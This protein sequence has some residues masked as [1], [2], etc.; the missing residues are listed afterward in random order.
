M[1][2]WDQNWVFCHQSKQHVWHKPKAVYHQKH[3]ILLVKHS[4][5]S[6]RFLCS[7]PGRFLRA[8]GKINSTKSWWK[9]WWNLQDASY[10]EDLFSSM[11]MTPNKSWRNHKNKKE[12]SRK[13]SR[14]QPIENEL[15][16]LKSLLTICGGGEYFNTIDTSLCLSYL[17]HFRDKWC[18]IS[19]KTLPHNQC[20]SP[21]IMAFSMSY[22]E[23]IYHAS[24]CFEIIFETVII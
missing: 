11:T 20:K 5:S 1:N 23:Q 19:Y 3:T 6:M 24:I 17:S 14:S 10:L 7:S 2:W 22:L 15:N 18:H 4:G 21:I 16:F 12:L 8:E 13:E 9:S